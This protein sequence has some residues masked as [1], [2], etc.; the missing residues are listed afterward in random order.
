MLRGG[1]EPLDVYRHISAGING[2]SMP[3]LVSTFSS[4]PD[5]MWKL[6]AYVLALTNTRRNGETP[7]AGLLKPL[8]GVGAPATPSTDAAALLPQPSSDRARAA[9]GVRPVAPEAGTE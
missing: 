4:E 9:G 1:T 7:E 3:S 6:T 2:T 5:T 8:P